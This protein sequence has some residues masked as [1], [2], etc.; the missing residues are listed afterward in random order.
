MIFLNSGGIAA[1]EI[2]NSSLKNIAGIRKMMNFFID[3]QIE[4]N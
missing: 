1:Q 2:I 4:T 3:P